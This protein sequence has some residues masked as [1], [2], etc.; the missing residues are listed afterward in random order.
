ME[1]EKINQRKKR[2]NVTDLNIRNRNDR[3][4]EATKNTVIVEEEDSDC[5]RIVNSKEKEENSR[6][7]GVRRVDLDDEKDK[8]T[9]NG[10]D[11]NG[12]LIIDNSVVCESDHEDESDNE[13]LNELQYNYESEDELDIPTEENF[14]KSST[15]VSGDDETMEMGFGR[16]RSVHFE[17]EKWEDGE[18]RIK[19]EK[20]TEYTDS[21]ESKNQERH[22]S[23]PFA[24]LERDSEVN[25]EMP[26][27]GLGRLQNVKSAN[28][29]SVR[30]LLRRRREEVGECVDQD[31][32]RRVTSNE[33]KSEGS[34]N[35]SRQERRQS[36][37]RERAQKESRTND[38]GSDGRGRNSSNIDNFINSERR[39]HMPRSRSPKREKGY[40]KGVTLVPVNGTDNSDG[41]V[42]SRRDYAMFKSLV[43][44]QN[45]GSD[46]LNRDV[47]KTTGKMKKLG[48]PKSG[49]QLR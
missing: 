29:E 48:P 43:G 31:S 38:R 16:P 6:N 27:S 8:C 28:R 23:H 46:K 34:V 4:T 35:I 19:K 3:V 7:S 1:K 22:E 42:I 10:L 36:R 9:K 39:Q 32:R 44:F 18:Y 45:M 17:D 14:L 26:F 33:R 15:S 11:S 30:E 20:E 49:N 5:E 2:V 24:K 12:D 47:W 13:M 21:W 25:Q 41:A 37:S 40:S